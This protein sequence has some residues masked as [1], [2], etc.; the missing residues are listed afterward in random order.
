M[1]RR[2]Y[3]LLGSVLAAAIPAVAQS[4]YAV[5]R[6]AILDP[7]HR[8]VPGAH[9]H[10]KSLGTGAEREATANDAGRTRSPDCSRAR[11][12]WRWTFMA[13]IRPRRRSNWKWASTQR[14]TWRCRV[15]G[16]AQ[17]VHGEGIAGRT[18]EDRGR[19]RG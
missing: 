4:N 6:G 8:A 15:G 3:F 7:H 2:V 19:Q 1:N 10:L 12:N 13:S 16:G 17:T 14:S 11:T 18:A 9:V 5:V